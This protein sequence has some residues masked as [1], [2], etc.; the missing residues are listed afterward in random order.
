MTRFDV[1]SIRE[2]AD[3]QTGET[4]KNTTRIGVAFPFKDKPGFTVLLDAVPAPQEGQFKLLLVEPRERDESRSQA[5]YG[6]VKGGQS[7]TPSD[8]DD[9]VPF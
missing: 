5:S 2:Y 3:R 4:R 6:D 7:P 9:E 1:I 8:L